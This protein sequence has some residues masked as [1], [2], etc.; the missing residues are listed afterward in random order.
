MFFAAGAN[1]S[2]GQ[3]RFNGNTVGALFSCGGQGTMTL[4]PANYTI[5]APIS[6]GQFVRS[7]YG[8]FQS[9]SGAVFVNP[10]N[11]TGQRY[12]VQQNGIIQTSGGGSAYFPGTVAGSFDT[13]GQYS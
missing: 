5:V 3:H 7:G 2:V 12:L 1:I 11:V 13:G 8:F 9:S 6:V 4:Q 10:G